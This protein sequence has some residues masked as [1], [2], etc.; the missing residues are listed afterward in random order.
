MTVPRS[1]VDDI[2]H[3]VRSLC[4]DVKKGRVSA[5]SLKEVIRLCD[6][7]D[8]QL[9]HDTGVLLLKCCGNPLSDLE[10][11]ERQYLA[12]QVE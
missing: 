2:D 5:D 1:S 9:H 7:S 8:Y 6:E 11:T 3:K 10:T 4:D 12:D